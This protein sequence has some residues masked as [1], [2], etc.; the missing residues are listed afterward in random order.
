M[1]GLPRRRFLELTLISAGA[2]LGSVACG[3][4]ASASA[5][6]SARFFP[7]SL[8][9]GDPRPTSVVLVHHAS[10]S[11]WLIARTLTRMDAA[12]DA[13]GFITVYPKGHDETWDAGSC[14]GLAMNVGID[15]TRFIAALLDDLA[16]RVCVDTH[17]VYAVGHRNGGQFAQRLACELSTRIAAV[18]SVEG[19]LALASCAPTRAVPVM[20]VHTSGTQPLEAYEATPAD[21]VA[22]WARIDGCTDAA[23]EMVYQRGNAR[24]DE[25]RACTGVAAVRECVVPPVPYEPW[26]GGNTGAGAPPKPDLDA[27]EALVQFFEAHPR[28]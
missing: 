1:A 28:P 22:A 13:H 21:S 14:C 5:L 25:R 2:A 26:P 17:R 16:S 11:N 8:A 24:C 6:D 9:S 4:D 3:S 23:P 19:Q 7:Q 20:L 12:A 27:T 10:F 18:G 15:D